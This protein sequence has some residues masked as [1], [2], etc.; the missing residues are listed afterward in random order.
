MGG[1]IVDIERQRAIDA[2]RQAGMLHPE[3]FLGDYGQ[4]GPF[5][6]LEKGEI[7]VN[8]F[9]EELKQFFTRPVTDQAIDEAFFKFILG[10]PVKRLRDLETLKKKGYKIFLLSNTNALMWYGF[11]LN[12]FKKDGHDINF[13]FDGI[14]TSFEVKAYKPDAA[15]FKAAERILHIKPSET[16]FFDDSE[17]NVKA[18]EAL[19][20]KATL[21]APGTEFMEYIHE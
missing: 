15:I 21:I 19:G 11:I 10:I 20:F 12:E 7:S 9:H 3:E 16:W 13:Y 14:I 17:S 4:K 2:L 18:A 1:V 5:L 6:A 8:E